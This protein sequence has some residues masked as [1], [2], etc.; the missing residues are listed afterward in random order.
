M[1]HRK[2]RAY[3]EREHGGKYI[4][5]DYTFSRN[6]AKA[7]NIRHTKRLLKKKTRQKSRSE[8]YQIIQKP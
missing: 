2:M 4:I 5:D 8:I 1:H 7:V 3:G 6:H